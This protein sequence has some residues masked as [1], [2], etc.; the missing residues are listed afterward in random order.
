MPKPSAGHDDAQRDRP[1]PW[2]P[3][4]HDR[5]RRWWSVTPRTAPA[6]PSLRG[7]SGRRSALV[8]GALLVGSGV[9]VPLA[10]H[11]ALWVDAEAV[12]GAWFVIWTIALAWLGYAGRAVEHDWGGDDSDHSPRWPDGIWALDLGGADVGEGCAGL[13]IGLLVLVV[14]AIVLSWLVPIVALVLYAMVQALLNRVGEHAEE[15]RG[16]LVPALRTA[17]LWAA[18]YTAPLALAVWAL[19]VAQ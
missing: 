4:D 12:I 3:A 16:R 19:H 18:V 1:T 13:I 17:V 8:L 5:A 2:S 14:A 15:T 9:L 7:V 11:R 6:S 10:L